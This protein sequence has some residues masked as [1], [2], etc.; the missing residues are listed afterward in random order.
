VSNQLRPHLIKHAYQRIQPHSVRTGFR[1]RTEARRAG[2]R[3]GERSSSWAP[4]IPGQHA[5]TNWPS[6]TNSNARLS[7]DPKVQNAPIG[8]V[9]LVSCIVPLLCKL[10]SCCVGPNDT[11]F[12]RSD[13][14]ISCSISFG[15]Q[16]KFDSQAAASDGRTLLLPRHLSRHAITARNRHRAHSAEPSAGAAQVRLNDR[17]RNAK[18]VQWR[19][20]SKPRAA[21]WRNAS[22][23]LNGDIY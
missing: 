7:C 22:S 18:S 4:L 6:S 12:D 13:N 21:L 23:R 9:E 1:S 11:Q 20:A 5:A 2:V 3:R 14:W 19:D 8:A 16:G 17:Q 15:T 10:S